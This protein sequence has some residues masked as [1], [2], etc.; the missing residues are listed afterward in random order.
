MQ[1][2]SI[3]SKLKKELR[4]LFKSMDFISKNF[5]YKKNIDRSALKIYFNIYQQLG[6]AWEFLG[7][8]CRHWDGYKKVKGKE[9]AC[10][11][12]GQVTRTKKIGRMLKPNSKK[13][14]NN[15]KEAELLNDS[16]EFHGALLNVDVHNSYKSKIDMAAER[17]V[18]LKERGIKCYIDNHLVN[19]EWENDGEK[20]GKERYGGFA[21]EIKRENLRKFPVMFDFDENHRLLGVS[22]LR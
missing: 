19:I 1:K 5:L 6:M 17:I 13:I 22:I 16:I 20:I 14:F 18:A 4:C 10:K 2:G 3:K 15:K 9:K 7:L 11:I 21:W 8:Q 12:C